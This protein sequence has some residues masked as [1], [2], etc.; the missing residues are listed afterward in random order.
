MN[1]RRTQFH[2][3]LVLA[4]LSVSSVA[5]IG[6]TADIDDPNSILPRTELDPGLRAIGDADTPNSDSAAQFRPWIPEIACDEGEA[7]CGSLCVTLEN[8]PNHCGSCEVQCGIGLVCNA[9]ACEAPTLIPPVAPAPPSLNPP[10]VSCDDGAFMCGEACVDLQT[11]ADHCGA[12]GNACAFGTCQA[13]RCETPV[14]VSAGGSHTC[15]LMSTGD[16]YCWG[17]NQFGQLGLDG[18]AQET[19]AHVEGV[20]SAVAISAGTT[21]SCALLDAGTVVCW[22]SGKADE[23]GTDEAGDTSIAR[24]VKLLGNPLSGVTEVVAGSHR[25]CAIT[26][27]GNVFCW[28]SGRQNELPEHRGPIQIKTADTPLANIIQ[29]ALGKTEAC[30]LSVSGHVYC[31]D[32][33]RA[34]ETFSP[35]MIDGSQIMEITAGA[36][37]FCARLSNGEAWCW[38]ANE[39]GQLGNGSTVRSETPVQ[40]LGA[41]GPLT[42]IVS[43]ASNANHTCVLRASRGVWCWGANQHGQVQ[44]QSTD[45]M[46]IASSVDPTSLPLQRTTALAVGGE[47]TCALSSIGETTC[48]GAGAQGQLGDGNLADRSAPVPVKWIH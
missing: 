20:H 9:G 22:G 27:G 4:S 26:D 21:H 44:N 8:N 43:I 36:A 48:W 33:L 13:G 30:A 40:V 34:S 14:Q 19:P 24:E 47:H 31:W 11:N 41:R 6:C 3:W 28:G 32:T 37:H 12:C 45:L 17:A 18:E 29:V 42:D 39:Q 5:L 10:T 7:L 25:T 23:L 38:G 16:V 1:A 46:W 15:A 35:E 2:L